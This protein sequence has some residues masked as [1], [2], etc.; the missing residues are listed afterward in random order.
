MSSKD[1]RIGICEYCGE[2][3]TR[4]RITGKFCKPAH[5]TAY[6]GLKNIIERA[7]NSAMDDTYKI[8]ELSDRYPHM[9]PDAKYALERISDYAL[10][11]RE[12]LIR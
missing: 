11:R 5:R 4:K 12:K 9:R 8:S 10:L 7:M 2:E 1:R 6:H 3:F